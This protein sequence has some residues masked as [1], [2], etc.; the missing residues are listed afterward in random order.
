MLVGLPALHRLLTHEELGESCRLW[1]FETA[2]DRDLSGIVLAEIWP[3][4]FDYAAVD[5][6]IKDARQVIAACRWILARDRQGGLRG[7]FGQPD[8]IAPSTARRRSRSRRS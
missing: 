3:S 2:W 5:H 8:D 4:L 7:S 6:P 1:P